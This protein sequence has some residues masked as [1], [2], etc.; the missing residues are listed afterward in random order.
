MTTLPPDLERYSRQ[1]I[2]PGI[3]TDGQERLLRARVTLVGC[4]ALGTVIANV[5]T[6]AGVG[7]L[8]IV[9]RDFVELS[10]LQRQVLFDEPGIAGQ[11]SQAI[12]A[13]RKLAR[14]NS[15]VQI[16]PI[17]ADIDNTNILHL[18]EG[19]DLVPDGMDN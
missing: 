2:F 19:V 15:T 8:R 16:E 5:L 14:I 9:D 11:L 13:A 3:G 4:G 17:V 1:T 18:F 10:N 7:F 12:A 6:R